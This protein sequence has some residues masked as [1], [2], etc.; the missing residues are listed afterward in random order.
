[1]CFRGAINGREMKCNEERG[2]EFP[3]VHSQVRGHAKA[4]TFAQ[5]ENKLIFSKVI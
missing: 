3:G 2:R 4:L 1:M 5:I